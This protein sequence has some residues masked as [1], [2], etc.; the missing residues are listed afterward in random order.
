VLSTSITAP[1]AG[2][3]MVHASSDNYNPKARDLLACAINVDG[4]EVP[5]S[6]RWF[7][8]NG[9]NSDDDCSSDGVVPVT[10]G[11]THMIALYALAVDSPKTAFGR[12]VIWAL[13]VPFDAVGARPTS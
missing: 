3:L 13:F 8:V 12:T 5:G 7:T 10:S 1:G 9:V 4:S 6:R 2:F 11:G